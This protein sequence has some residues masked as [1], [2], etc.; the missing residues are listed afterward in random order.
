MISVSSVLMP[1]RGTDTLDGCVW[2]VKP[3]PKPEDPPPTSL[4]FY[5]GTVT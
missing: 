3:P 1:D 5:L 2:P 4:E